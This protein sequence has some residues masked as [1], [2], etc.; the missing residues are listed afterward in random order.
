M[1]INIIEPLINYFSLKKCDKTTWPKVLHVGPGRVMSGSPT[2]KRGGFCGYE[3]ITFGGGPN[4]PT[5]DS[6]AQVATHRSIFLKI[7]LLLLL[8]T[9]RKSTSYLA[10]YRL[11]LFI[12]FHIVLE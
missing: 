10:E 6:Q 3:W 5:F 11:H 1:K 12:F 2:N 8:L 9:K 7:L 4:G